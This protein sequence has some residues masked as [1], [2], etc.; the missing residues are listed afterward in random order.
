MGRRKAKETRGIVDAW[1]VGAFS[2]VMLLSAPLGDGRLLSAQSGPPVTVSVG[3]QS[4][5]VPWHTAPITNRVNPAVG[6]GTDRSLKS[7][8]NWNFFCALHIGFFRSHWWMTGVSVEPEIGIGRSLP[9]GFYSDLRLGVGYMHYFW[10][11]KRLELHDGK[12]V[13]ATNWG[14]PSLI[15]PLSAT[16][17][18]R[19]DPDDPLPVSPFVSARWGVQGLF[20]DEVPVVTH[21]FLLGGLRFERRRANPA[22]RV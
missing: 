20:R 18:Y 12:Y 17:G 8:R 13:A 10:R 1:R 22:G 7:G 9:G 21:L 5:T 11:R 6:V 15:M 4:F 2:L 3:T 14:S 16:L 19:G